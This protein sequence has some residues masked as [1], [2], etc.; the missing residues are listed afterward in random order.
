M[1]GMTLRPCLCTACL[2]LCLEPIQRVELC[3]LYRIP[4]VKVDFF[5]N[6]SDSKRYLNLYLKYDWYV[7]NQ[8]AQ[9]FDLELIISF[10]KDVN[11]DHISKSLNIEVLFTSKETPNNL[12][13]IAWSKL[14]ILST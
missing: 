11:N 14:A 9:Y 8:K 3:T 1:T 2:R 6:F 13:K 5:L 7:S 10:A 4:Q 12:V